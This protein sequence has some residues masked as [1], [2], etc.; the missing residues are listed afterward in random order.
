MGQ[1]NMVGRSISF[2]DNHVSFSKIRVGLPEHNFFRSQNIK[3]KDYLLQI[4]KLYIMHTLNM[5]E[6]WNQLV[7]RTFFTT[8]QKSIRSI[9]NF[10]WV[11]H[12]S[13]I[14]ITLMNTIL[15]LWE[16]RTYQESVHRCLRSSSSCAHRCPYQGPVHQCL[17]LRTSRNA[18]SLNSA[19][20][21]IVFINWRRS[22]ILSQN[23]Y[24]EMQEFFSFYGLSNTLNDIFNIHNLL[25]ITVIKDYSL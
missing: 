13:M 8:L 2:E 16:T 20:C 22:S 11:L 6:V 24:N 1:R 3:L 17:V 5:D 21:Y 9:M 7:M 4:L 19:S 23:R 12:S 14:V 25:K 15:S 18:N 10:T